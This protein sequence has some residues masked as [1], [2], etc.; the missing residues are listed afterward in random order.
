ML[1][2][3]DRPAGYLFRHTIPREAKPAMHPASLCAIVIFLYELRL[4]VAA[5][6]I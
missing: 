2:A 6:L 1:L 4:D 5:N 3:A